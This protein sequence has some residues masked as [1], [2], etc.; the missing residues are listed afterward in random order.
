MLTL[1][2]IVFILCFVFAIHLFH[3]HYSTK[4]QVNNK[5][6]FSIGGFNTNLKVKIIDAKDILKPWYSNDL[7]SPGYITNIEKE[8]FLIITGNGS[9]YS[10]F[11]DKL[12]LLDSNFSS[13]LTSKNYLP[14]KDRTNLTGRLGVRGLYYD[15]KSKTIF[16]AYGLKLQNPNCFTLAIDSAKFEDVNQKI[17]FSNFYQGKSCSPNP[18]GHESAGKI[19]RI[20]DSIFVAFG[21]FGNYDGKKGLSDYISKKDSSNKDWEF[22]SI[23]KININTKKTQV[24]AKGLRNVEGMESVKDSLFITS[25]GPY[26]GDIFS[27]VE[28]HDNF[29]WPEYSYGLSYENFENI[30]IKP[31]PPYK[32]PTFYFCPDVG[33]SAILFYKN[34]SIPWF[35]DKFIMATLIDKSF[36][37][38]DYSFPLGRIR[39]VEKYNLGY[40]IRDLSV[41]DNGSIYLIT[42]EGA[43]LILS[44]FLK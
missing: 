30:Y 20:G 19:T 22:G 28:E 43:I 15:A 27:K 32:D 6:E 11:S 41:G 4:I 36:Y 34:K 18:N 40:R 23:L 24:Y 44:N 38:L 12:K 16:V 33:V 17:I 2:G 13:L 42:D 14:I 9:L 25:H 21:S 26:G 7:L 31:V 35:K 8:K 10:F 39:S 1:A 5:T 29:G 37:L 3:R